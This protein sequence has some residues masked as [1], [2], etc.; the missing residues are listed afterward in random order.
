MAPMTTVTTGILGTTGIPEK[1]TELELSKQQIFN[2]LMAG[3]TLE[4][5][6]PSGDESIRFQNVL[7]VFVSR[8]RTLIGDLGADMKVGALKFRQFS[9]DEGDDV[10]LRISIEEKVEKKFSVRVI[11][12]GWSET[13]LGKGTGGE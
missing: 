7:R 1:E 9:T 6:F 2:H 3:E 11:S 5:A 4:L 12:P 8:Q 13:Q 10:I